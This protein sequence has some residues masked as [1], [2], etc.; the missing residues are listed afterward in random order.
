MIN[1]KSITN[2][3]KQ[4]NN[5][6]N[7]HPVLLIWSIIFTFFVCIMLLLCINFIY[8]QVKTRIIIEDKNDIFDEEEAPPTPTNKKEIVKRKLEDALKDALLKLNVEDEIDL[9]NLDM[10]AIIEDFGYKSD[11][12]DQFEK[13]INDSNGFHVDSQII[14]QFRV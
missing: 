10:N 7:G 11:M 9:E 5:G 3:L 1:D 13:N 2:I 4:I 14:K 8:N 12:T 6:T